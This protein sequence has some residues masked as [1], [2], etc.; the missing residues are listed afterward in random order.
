MSQAFGVHSQKCAW[1]IYVWFEMSMYVEEMSIVPSGKTNVEGEEYRE[2]LPT[3]MFIRG[4]RLTAAFHHMS[5]ST[6]SVDPLE[7]QS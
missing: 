2:A 6:E 4:R 1:C 7:F 5:N 3:L